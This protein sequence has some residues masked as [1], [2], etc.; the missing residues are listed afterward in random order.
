VAPATAQDFD[1]RCAAALWLRIGNTSQGQLQEISMTSSFLQSCRTPLRG[2]IVAAALALT[3]CAGTPAPREQ[4]AVT[5]SAISNAESERARE[6]SPVEMRNAQDKLRAA[7]AAMAAA[8]NDEARRLAEQAELD[9]R[10][11]ERRAQAVKAQRAVA[12]LREGIRTLQQ[13]IQPR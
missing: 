6:H 3:A 13:E 1:C 4:M 9:A 10:L 8:R 7:E 12:E 5:R 2:A 11:A